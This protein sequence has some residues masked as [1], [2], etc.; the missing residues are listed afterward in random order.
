[1]ST[2]LEFLKTKKAGLEAM[3]E[4][5]KREYEQMVANGNALEGA[6]GFC[7][8]MIMELE[9]EE[10]PQEALFSKGDK[11]PLEKKE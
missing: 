8:D 4:Q 1:M 7:K 11:K 5:W 10:P 9:K 2:T 6:L 3:L